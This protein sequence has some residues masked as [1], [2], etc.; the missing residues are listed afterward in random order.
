MVEPS[1][2]DKERSFEVIEGRD[3]LNT[4]AADTSGGQSS[5]SFKKKK[6]SLMG[7]IK[8]WKKK[9]K[10]LHIDIDAIEERSVQEYKERPDEE[11]LAARRISKKK[12]KDEKRRSGA[13]SDSDSL[14]IAQQ[15]ETK[16]E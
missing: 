16:G 11:N 1:E 10:N 5:K 8:F 6:R 12:K 7:S 14:F 3:R 9:K 15:E 2:E 13:I 4:L